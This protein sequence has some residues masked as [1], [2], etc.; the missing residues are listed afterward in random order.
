MTPLSA[1]ISLAT[2]KG[3]VTAAP[4]PAAYLLA[5]M[6]TLMVS[7]GWIT[8]DAILPDKDPIMNGFPYFEAK[9]SDIFSL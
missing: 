9:V 7:I 5:W 6:T 4:L 3:L 1:I 8:L 2:I